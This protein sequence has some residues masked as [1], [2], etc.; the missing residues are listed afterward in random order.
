MYV[1]RKKVNP[2]KQQLFIGLMVMLALWLIVASVLDR[3]PVR[4][5]LDAYHNMLGMEGQN[6]KSY[7]EL[8]KENAR[9]DS[10]VFEMKTS[11]EKLKQAIKYQQA[12]VKVESENLNMR[13]KPA[14]GSEVILQLPVGS[15]VE[16]LY[17]DEET[18]RIGGEY[19]KWC[20]IRYAGKE[21][22]VWGNYL[23]MLN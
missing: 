21:G 2:K 16:I 20:K 14:L 9:L 13:N 23:E 22:W 11:L 15:V 3:S 5:I 17:F 6:W 1:G 12:V 8:E 10:M 7:G 4:L 19:G 18:F